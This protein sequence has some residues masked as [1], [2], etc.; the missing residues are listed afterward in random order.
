MSDASKLL[1]FLEAK[2]RKEAACAATRDLT[3][4]ISR[5]DLETG[6][7]YCEID[8]VEAPITLLAEGHVGNSVNVRIVDGEVRGIGNITS[9]AVSAETVQGVRD[10]AEIAG[11]IVDSMADAADTAGKTLAEVVADAASASTLLDGVEDVAEQA[12]K[13]L[14]QIVQDAS[15]AGE[16]AA[17]AKRM[18]QEASSQASQAAA[19]ASS[20]YLSAS[21]ALAHLSDIEKVA[22]AIEWIRDHGEYAATQDAQPLEG[23]WYFSR[24][25]SG[26]EADPY[27]YAVA[28]VAD[29]YAL[30]SDATAVDG[31]SYYE[32]SQSEPY[33]YTLADTSPTYPVTDDTEPQE[34]K[35]YWQRTGEGTEQS[36]YV[37][38]QVQ[39]P[40]SYTATTDA[41]PQDGKVYYVLSEG[42]YVIADVSEGFQDGVTYY[43][44]HPGNPHDLGLR[45]RVP[46][47]VE[48]L[49]E[50]VPGNPGAQGLYE[51]ASVDE[52]IQGYLMAHVAVDGDS[53]WVQVDEHA[54]IQLSATEGIRL[55]GPTELDG[56]GNPTAYG[57]VASYGAS[58]T[59][60]NVGATH[61]ETRPDRL[62]FWS[63]G[64]SYDIALAEA[65]R[66]DPSYVVTPDV[67][68]PGE[69]AYIAVDGR[70][71]S[72][73]YMNRAVVVKELRFAKWKWVPRS[74]DNLSL[75]WMG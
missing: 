11:E 73:F 40:D 42:D 1:G 9:P 53:L 27:F 12:G 26:T 14:A 30:T 8:G 45:E 75:K 25:G 58:S 20:A 62:S 13:T 65:R 29:D 31:K 68:M 60:G 70:G 34:G 2:A 17:E 71:D 69:V 32:R 7:R 61:V 19:S 46:A 64:Y 43:E 56:Q 54:R 18:A 35:A 72:V 67:A 52:S 57:V 5:V 37:Y 50:R 33:T 63:A 4:V 16:N 66:D 41:E 6:T 10:Y 39:V 28:T 24:S 22:G 3:A 48:G 47:D 23:K 51:L 15:E 36:P 21:G 55:Y 49:Y 74:N 44:A 38:T 59:V